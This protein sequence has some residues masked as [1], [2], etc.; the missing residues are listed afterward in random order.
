[1]ICNRCGAELPENSLF[2]F[3][4][5]NRLEQAPSQP[6][7]QNSA[8]PFGTKSISDRHYS[9]EDIARQQRESSNEIGLDL[10]YDR[11]RRRKKR[12][13]PSQGSQ[14]PSLN[15]N[16]N[17]SAGILVGLAAAQQASSYT[18]SAPEQTAEHQPT[19]AVP[20]EVN[21][22]VQ[23]EF[24]SATQTENPQ[25]EPISQSIQASAPVQ[26]ETPTQTG[27]PQPEPVSHKEQS[28]APDQMNTSERETAPVTSQAKSTLRYTITSPPVPL[29]L[30]R[31]TCLH[32]FGG[33]ISSQVEELRRTYIE[34]KNNG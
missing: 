28:E 3:R 29:G 4:C 7:E 32:L 31:Q 33:N 8:S 15:S 9:L 21:A 10:S 26:I 24:S 12:H 19:P 17:E 13:P 14:P 11:P 30:Q 34:K 2:C 22:M 5:G 23:N 20:A 27:T 25:P 16:S 6:Q 18:L 1:M